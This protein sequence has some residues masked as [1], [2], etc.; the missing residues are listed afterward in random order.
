LKETL[1]AKAE[2]LKEAVSEK[3]EALKEAVSEKAGA[4][5]DALIDLKDKVAHRL[6]KDPEPDP[7]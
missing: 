2:S 1:G 7:K 4:L 5:K 3:A 6:H